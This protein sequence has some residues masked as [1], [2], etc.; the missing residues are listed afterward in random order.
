MM[1]HEPNGQHPPSSHPHR[2]GFVGNLAK[3]FRLFWVRGQ[4]CILG[5][6]IL[7]PQRLK[8]LARLK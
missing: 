8:P 3:K 4:N 2:L 6:K 5:Y 1:Q 7:V